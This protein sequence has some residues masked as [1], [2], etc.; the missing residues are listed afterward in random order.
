MNYNGHSCAGKTAPDALFAKIM[1]TYNTQLRKLILPEYGRNIQNMV[2]HCMTIADRQQRTECAYSIV[3]AMANLFPAS[4]NNPDFKRQLWDHLAIMSDFELDIDFPFDVVRPEQLNTLP[5]AIP[6]D[7]SMFR[8]RHY[9]KNL[10][11]MIGRAVEMPVGPER[12]AL[13]LLL[14]NHMKKLMLAISPEGVDDEKVF[15]DL[16][17]FSHGAIRLT[18]ETCRLHEFKAEVIPQQSKKKKR[19]K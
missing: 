7:T 6:Y 1:L 14:A 10:E 8:W 4:K 3:A 16:A 9:G 11:Y 13:V 17:I 15:N 19:K 12:D 18:P 5:D 2:D